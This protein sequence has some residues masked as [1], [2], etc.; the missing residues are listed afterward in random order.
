MS[1]SDVNADDHLLRLFRVIVQESNLRKDQNATAHAL[2]MLLVRVG[3]SWRSIYTLQN[4]TDDSE[5]YGVDAGTLL[6]A[7]Y[8]AYLQAALICHDPSESEALAQDYIDFQHIERFKLKESIMRHE[9]S[10]TQHLQSSPNRDEGE[11]R[12]NNE[13]DRVK[14]RFLNERRKKDGTIKHGPGTRNTWYRGTLAEV[15]DRVGNS[16]EY[17]SVL[18]HFHGCVHSSPMAVQC[19]PLVSSDHLLHWASTIVGRI[20]NFCVK[21]NHIVLDNVDQQILDVLSKPYFGPDH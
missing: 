9:T 16:D 13:Y 18:R 14:A 21:H 15:A 6:R 3:N 7:M 12:L 4:N 19:G 1:E 2:L 5:G 10:L 11:K 17:D 20:A 8:D